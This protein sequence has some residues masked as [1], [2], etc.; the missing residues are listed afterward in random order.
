MICGSTN[1]LTWGSE[2][3]KIC[4]SDDPMIWHLPFTNQTVC[5][6]QT[7]QV[8]CVVDQPGGQSWPDQ[9]GGICRP[10]QPGAR[11]QQM[12]TKPTP[13]NHAGPYNLPPQLHDICM[14]FSL[15]TFTSN[16][17]SSHPF[18]T[19]SSLCVWIQRIINC[20]MWPLTLC[21]INTRHHTTVPS[22]HL[23][24][25]SLPSTQLFNELLWSAGLV[26]C[27]RAVCPQCTPALQMI[28]I[29]SQT[30]RGLARRTTATTQHSPVSV[31]SRTVAWPDVKSF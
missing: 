23:C 8:D 16:G 19:Q 22:Q 4:W 14:I 30:E 28:F 12:R 25:A 31:D 18:L 20:C 15:I 7:N 10:D 5:V 13:G 2:D 6:D 17:Q 24:N 26:F 9:P 1:L 11:S 27:G 29:V 21:L 3:L